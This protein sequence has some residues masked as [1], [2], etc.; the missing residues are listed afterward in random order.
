MKNV[1]LRILVLVE[2]RLHPGFRQSFCPWNR[3][4]PRAPTCGGGCSR[5]SED[6]EN[7]SAELT[8]DSQ[9]LSEQAGLSAQLRGAAIRP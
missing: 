9:G 5:E 6:D 2:L 4:R 7:M 1:D 8:A 3:T